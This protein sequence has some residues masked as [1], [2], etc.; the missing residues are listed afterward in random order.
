MIK[1]LNMPAIFILIVSFVL[2]VSSYTAAASEMDHAKVLGIK[3][4]AKFMKAGT[5]DWK[6]LEP[7]M[8]L[9]EGDSMKT[10]ANSEA[11]LELSGARKTAEIVVRKDSEFSFATFRHDEAAMTDQTLLDVGTGGVL[12][13]AEKLI[14]ESKFQVKTPTSIVGIRGTIFE[15][16]ASTA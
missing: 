13:K 6:T 14:G 5:N 12:V 3:G 10:G 11:T 16:Y 9:S 4:E 8:I 7:G 2:A 15:V 1:K